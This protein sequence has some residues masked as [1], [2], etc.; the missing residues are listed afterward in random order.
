MKRQLY[1]VSVMAR[2]DDKDGFR[3]RARCYQLDVTARN[4]CQARRL[5]LDALYDSGLLAS[6]FVRIKQV[7]R[8]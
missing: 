1:A 3:S 5:A 4:E 6:Q 2:A 7:G 8:V